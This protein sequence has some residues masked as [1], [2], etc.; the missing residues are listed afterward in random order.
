[1]QQ[2]YIHYS[3][4]T[5]VGSVVPAFESGALHPNLTTYRAGDEKGKLLSTTHVLGG[6]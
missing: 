6:A 5:P 1:M 3:N 2:L 4:I